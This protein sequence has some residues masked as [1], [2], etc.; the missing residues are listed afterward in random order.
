MKR[1]IVAG[2]VTAMAVLLSAC[3]TEPIYEA[4]HPIIVAS[5]PMVTNQRVET[6]IKAAL[7]NEKWTIE[8]VTPGKIVAKWHRHATRW[9]LVSITY[10]AKT[11][12]T[13]LESSFELYQEN[14]QIHASYNQAIHELEDRITSN[15]N[16]TKG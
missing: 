3:Q 15:L 2:C 4:K 7:E 16:L 1:L 12:S 10:D 9:A 8:S 11:F 13:H 6:A 5:G 14:G